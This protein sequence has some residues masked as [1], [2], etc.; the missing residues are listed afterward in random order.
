MPLVARD[1]A[2]RVSRG[3]QPARSFRDE[4]ASACARAV[5]SE[6]DRPG[7]PLSRQTCLDSLPCATLEDT[8][9]AAQGPWGLAGR[10]GG[11]LFDR[12]RSVNERAAES[13]TGIPD[14]QREPSGGTA[15]QPLAHEDRRAA[16]PSPGQRTAMA[17]ELPLYRARRAS[18]ARGRIR[19]HLL[20]L[21]RRRRSSE[22]PGG[23]SNRF[24]SG[25]T[26]QSFSCAPGF[27]Q[28][29]GS[30]ERALLELLR[31]DGREHRVE[32]Q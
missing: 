27:S 14:R 13:R 24:R 11:M 30:P 25:G 20:R 1:Q 19:W 4:F 15:R 6:Q 5:G 23:G 10:F 3:M 2:E 9:T 32:R 7:C 16:R 29:A 31:H 28:Q 12:G 21:R 26:G 18:A 8:L 22:C 17:P